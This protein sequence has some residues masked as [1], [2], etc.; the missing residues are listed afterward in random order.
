MQQVQ[1]N[2]SG[3]TINDLTVAETEQAE[4]KAGRR[5]FSSAACRSKRLRRRC[6]IWNRT[7]K[8]KVV[9]PTPAA[10]VV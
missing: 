7:V 9:P 10:R 5:R 1:T 8:S 4:I 2:N 3:Q 6:P